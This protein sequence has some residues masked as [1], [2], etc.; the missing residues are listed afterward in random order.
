VY[1]GG[2]KG[3]DGEYGTT[4]DFLYDGEGGI[5]IFGSV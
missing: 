2:G 3:I 4:V 5:V 1:S